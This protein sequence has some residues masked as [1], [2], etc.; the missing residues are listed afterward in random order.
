MTHDQSI[1]D[2]LSDDQ[3]RA[4]DADREHV[5]EQLRRAH[6]QGRIDDDELADR[7]GRCYGARTFAELHRLTV[8]LRDPYRRESDQLGGHREPRHRVRFALAG[9]LAVWAVCSVAHGHSR[10]LALLAVLAVAFA[11]TQLVR[12]MRA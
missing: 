2:P 8:D 6:G 10:A 4:G 3:L 1:P 7:L 9:L 12:A 11:V 5:A